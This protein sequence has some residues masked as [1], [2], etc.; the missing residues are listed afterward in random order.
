MNFTNRDN[1]TQSAQ[2]TRS[3]SGN[4]SVNVAG[5]LN[6]AL[7]NGRKHGRDWMKGTFAIML[8]SLTIITL[9]TVY[10][11]H[12]N[13]SEAKY[14]NGKTLQAVFLQNGQVYFG[15]IKSISQKYIELQNIFYLNNPSSSSANSSANNNNTLSLVKL[16]CELHGPTDRMVI[17]QEQVTY[18]ENLRTDGNVAKAVDQYNQ[19]YPKGQT[20]TDSNST[21]SATQAAGTTPSATDTTKKQ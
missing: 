17:N 18:W 19:K 9:G 21:N 6:N 14:V 13:P 12:S 11:L 4:S 7:K 5:P 20:C 16:G 8:I 15:H 1:N 2:Q 3:N 10:L